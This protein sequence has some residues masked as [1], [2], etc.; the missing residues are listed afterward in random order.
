VPQ[1]VNVERDGV[2]VFGSTSCEPACAAAA[3]DAPTVQ[4]RAFGAFGSVQVSQLPA[5]GT[6]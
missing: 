4:V 5:S 1:G 3:A 2:V 6:N